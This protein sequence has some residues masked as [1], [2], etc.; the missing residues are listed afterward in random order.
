LVNP[1]LISPSNTMKRTILA[2]LSLGL[3]TAVLTAQI[4][5]S[6]F[7]STFSAIASRGYFF[8]APT[9]LILTH[10]Q[11]PDE[12]KRGKQIIAVYKLSAAPPAYSATVHVT[13]V[14]YV[15][16]LDSKV[17]WRLPTPIIYNKGDYVAVIGVCGPNS[18]IVANSYGGGNFASQVRG[19]PIRLLRCG[20]QANIAGQK[21]VGGMFSEGNGAIARVRLTFA[22][23]PQSEVHC[24]PS[25]GAAE[26]SICDEHPA[27]PG[28]NFGLTV[29]SG[30]AA[31]TGV[32]LAIG[33]T[34]LNMHIPGLGT[35]CT[36][37]V[38]I[39]FGLRAAT[40]GGTNYLFAIP[41]ASSGTV[42]LQAALTG[43]VGLPLTNGLEVT[44][45]N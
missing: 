30:G 15:D 37:P 10:A 33:L 18:G 32:A 13:P 12:A 21:G 19:L 34:R 5:M 27:I 26:L 43:G 9:A 38:L 42:N 20:I 23:G 40:T 17:R 8:Q 1:Q 4:P 6:K 14:A 39:V 31:N 29:K 22:G 11:V 25:N 36:N 3:A 44:V 24:A 41:S 7:S 35:L 2:V 45:G 16:N 28:K